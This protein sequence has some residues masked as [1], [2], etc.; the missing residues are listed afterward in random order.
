MILVLVYSMCSFKVRINVMDTNQ[1]C[2]T[3]SKLNCHLTDK[4]NELPCLTG[5]DSC[6]LVSFFFF[7]WDDLSTLVSLIWSVVRGQDPY[8]YKIIYQGMLSL[9]QSC[10]FALLG[11][12]P[13]KQC[14]NLILNQHSAQIHAI[15]SPGAYFLPEV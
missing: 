8:M 14:E 10:S 6:A 1:D 2:V 3:Q 5:H 4:M 11:L 7:C 15:G 9:D 12:N 13:S